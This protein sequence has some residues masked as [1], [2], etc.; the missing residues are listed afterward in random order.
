MTISPFSLWHR[1]NIGGNWFIVSPDGETHLRVFNRD[2]P[3]RIE[4]ALCR[5]LNSTASKFTDSDEEMDL[6]GPR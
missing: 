6:R 3:K 4:R 2:E 1:E 5:I